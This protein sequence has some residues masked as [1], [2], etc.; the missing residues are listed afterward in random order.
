MEAEA[1]ADL[2]A[3]AEAEAEAKVEAEAEA[4]QPPGRLSLRDETGVCRRKPST[5]GV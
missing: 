3:E 2:E 4:T 5:S 1:E